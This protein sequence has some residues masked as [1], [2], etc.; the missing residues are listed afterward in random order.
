MTSE[1]ARDRPVRDLEAQSE[2]SSKAEHPEGRETVRSAVV[3]LQRSAGN[4]AVERLAGKP[5]DLSLRADMEERLGAD[6]SH[7]RLYSDERAEAQARAEDAAAFVRGADV[8]FSEGMYQPDSAAGR[9]VL[10]HELAHVVQ[11]TRSVAQPQSPPAELERE[12]D[13]AAADAGAVTGHAPEG[14]VQRVKA[15]LDDDV[16]AGIER[17]RQRYGKDAAN[18]AALEEVLKDLERLGRTHPDEALEHL[19][20]FER[21]APARDIE[22]A[23]GDAA[24]SAAREEKLLSH[25]QGEEPGEALSVR[26]KKV[27]RLG[28]SGRASAEAEAVR[29]GIGDPRPPGHDTHHIAA[30]K[31][32]RAAVARKI[33]LD[34]GI[35]P[36]IDP[37]NTYH[38]PRTSTD[39]GTIPEAAT[40]H[41]TV[42]TNGYYQRLTLRL[43][44]A[45]KNGTVRETLATIQRELAEGKFNAARIGPSR[46]KFADWLLEQQDDLD[47]M[48]SEEFDE[49]L[50]GLARNPRKAASGFTS[51]QTAAGEKTAAGVEAPAAQEP[52]HAPKAAASTPGTAG[53]GNS[54]EQLPAKISKPI[55][56][57]VRSAQ[58]EP[59]AMTATGSE[60]T[61]LPRSSTAVPKQAPVP[62]D[63]NLIEPFA[64]SGA[65]ARNSIGPGGVRKQPNSS[66]W[67]KEPPPKRPLARPAGGKQA[68]TVPVAT[69]SN[70]FVWERVTEVVAPEST[71]LETKPVA[72]GGRIRVGGAA[73]A[74]RVAGSSG[75]APESL[76]PLGEPIA[77]AKQAP[78][79]KRLGKATQ[80]PSAPSGEPIAEAK[81]APVEKPPGKTTQKPSAPSGEPIAEAKQ[82]PVEEPPGK[83]TE[84]PSE[85]TRINLEPRLSVPESLSSA[86]PEA[87]ARAQARQELTDNAVTVLADLQARY[88][89]RKEFAENWNKF[90]HAQWE[91]ASV[92]I[93]DGSPSED[94]FYRATDY[95]PVT[96]NRG[97]LSYPVD[98]LLFFNKAAA[99]KLASGSKDERR[100]L[101]ATLAQLQY[102]GWDTGARGSDEN[103]FRSRLTSDRRGPLSDEA[104][105]ELL[106]EIGLAPQSD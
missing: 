86:A 95:A 28:V 13:L 8:T 18:S 106:A 87:V 47:W 61:R 48:T 40:R 39:P 80:K 92:R 16:R 20:N 56:P 104:F 37:E 19:R 93:V 32:P 6:L 88:L 90:W 83:T 103:P 105:V 101:T 51:A 75:K 41:Q 69:E 12:A 81:Q 91:G 71:D 67:L 3:E 31:D 29:A 73:S 38:L 36:R 46:Q 53:P 94:L 78:V 55:V 79:E 89:E 42:H 2:S 64:A 10:A 54:P 76:A 33:L 35:N 72:V 74:A 1:A 58:A 44:E 45:K 25:E 100:Q 14:T 43:I 11:Q 97:G 59:D 65:P 30:D 96:G 82:A 21:E 77:G 66:G 99:R 26:E 84:K 52:G 17:L 22:S 85:P 70:P 102:R 24:K 9:V 49:V 68:P 63:P 62:I 23:F 7:V 57:G 27:L 98:G 15:V 5:L 60:S 34:E 4:R 50:E